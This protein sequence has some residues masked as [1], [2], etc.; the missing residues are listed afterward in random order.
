MSS[1]AT[2]WGPLRP[3]F[4]PES[5]GGP[6]R[7]D[8][9][10]CPT[11]PPSGPDPARVSPSPMPDRGAGPTTIGTCGPHFIDSSPSA[12]LQSS[13]ESRLRAALEGAG[14]PLY[15][16]TWKVW[17]MP[18]GPPIC[19]L[20][21]SVPRTNDS[22]SFGGLQGWPTT[23]ASDARSSASAAYSTESGRHG[24]TT[25]TDAARVARG[26]ATPATRDHKD[27]GDLSG[28]MFRQDGRPRHDTVPRQAAMIVGSDSQTGPSG[29]LNPGHSRWLMGY[30]PEWDDC[31]ATVT[32]SSRRSRRS[33]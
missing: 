22:G 20:R 3:T 12:A 2:L 32:P 18:L 24:G 8:L 19:A 15:V 1:Q 25:L 13:L 10:E 17:D 31:A 26:W 28:S 7:S 11:T 29:Q 30:P 21:A 4:L 16:L 6:T 9:P 33:S 5:A 27:T 14:S 23:T